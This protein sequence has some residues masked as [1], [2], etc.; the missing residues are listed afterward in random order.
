[1]NTNNM[2]L[3]AFTS[4]TANYLPKARV[5]AYS[6]KKYHPDL[7]FSVILCDAVPE[8]FDL[9][10]EPFDSLIL[11][12]DLSIPN[13]NSWIFKHSL[14]ELCTAV[15]GYAFLEIIARFQAEK[16]FYFDPDIVV[17]NSIC[18]L[19][20]KLDDASILL[21]PHQTTPE[22]DK[23]AIIDNEICSLKHGVF[24]LGFLGICNNAAGVAF[25]RWWRD[26]LHDF[27]FDDKPGGLFTDQRWVDLAPAFFED[28]HILRS[29]AC[30]V[31]TWN[32]THRIASG[33]MNSGILI[34]GEPLIFFHFS[35][36][37]SGEQKIML[38]K[39][40]GKS[41]VLKDLRRWYI[42]ECNN[43]GQKAQ[44]LVPFIYGSYDNEV[45][46]GKHERLL[47]R[48]RDDLQSRF[49]NPYSTRDFENSYFH[50][51]RA[52]VP[53]RERECGGS[54]DTVESL[55]FALSECRNELNTIHNSLSWKI[56][57]KIDKLY[58]FCR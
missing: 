50:W 26:R 38:R 10:V 30:N 8:S 7:C 44:G 58:R 22:R 46:I 41:G 31:A 12:S 47:Y 33:S 48:S 55:Q 4:I 9:E 34:N 20:D 23:C 24:N 17:L 5:L 21:T 27:C 29:P 45:I 57:K 42:N 56:L 43:M 35:G 18:L 53:E 54:N 15:K 36:I 11:I 1:M 16:V 6:L 51:Y 37:D 49:N 19:I 14:I 3:H 52:N 13:I 28:I 25:L 32:L 2:T 39:Y 40:I